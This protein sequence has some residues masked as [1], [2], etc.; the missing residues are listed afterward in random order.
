V[1]ERA[2]LSAFKVTGLLAIVRAPSAESAVATI[3]AL[4]KGGVTGIEVTFST[5]DAAAVIAETDRRHGS[6][7][8]LGAGTVTTPEQ[9]EQAVEA[10]ASYLVSPGTVPRL[11]EAMRATGAAILLGAVTPTE[12]MTAVALG[13]T[14]VKIFPGSLGG[15]SY[16]KAL[17]GPFP[18]VALMP[19]GGVNAANIGEWFAAGAVAVGAGSDL[20]NPE[21]MAEGRFDEITVTAQQFMAALRVVRAA[22]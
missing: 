1:S 10:G 11:A 2:E 8:L 19:T 3:D 15:P 4:V 12:L 9:A 16:L 20:C 21:A 17:R 7:V 5:P 22:T 18:D 6:R 14:A 13:A